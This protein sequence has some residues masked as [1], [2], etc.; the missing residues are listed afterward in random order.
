MSKEKI[1]RIRALGAK[2]A[3]P[4]ALLEELDRIL[5]KHAG[6]NW[7]YVWDVE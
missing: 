6:K 5:R 1:L 7:A 4:S 2:T 3:R